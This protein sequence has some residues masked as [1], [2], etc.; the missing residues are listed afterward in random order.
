[1]YKKDREKMNDGKNWRTT[2]IRWQ[3]YLKTL[4]ALIFTLKIYLSVSWSPAYVSGGRGGGGG[5]VTSAVS[6]LS[7]HYSVIY[8]KMLLSQVKIKRVNILLSE[9]TLSFSPQS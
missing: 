2:K 8:S 6:N 9:H 1:M 5:G 7:V 3:F 4:T